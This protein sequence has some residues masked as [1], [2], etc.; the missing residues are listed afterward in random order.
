MIELIIFD[1]D[2]TLWR[3]NDPISGTPE[4]LNS[5][6]QKAVQIRFL[7]NNSSVSSL[8]VAEKLRSMGFIADPGEV[9]CSGPYA[10]DVCRSR[11][12]D[13]VYVIGGL[14]LERS[15]GDFRAPDAN[16]D[17]V[18]VGID[19][20]FTYDK[21]NQALQYILRG[22]AFIATNRDATY[23][24]EQ[25]RIV[26]GAGAIVASIEA[27]SGVEAEVLGKPNPGMILEILEKAGVI[28]GNC[29][30][31]GDRLDTDIKA[32][33]AAGCQTALV[34]TGA[35]MDPIPGVVTAVSVPDLLSRLP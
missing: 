21:C 24:M 29:L 30:V 33:W 28:P 8:D 18:V 14:G 32:G 4:A 15:F 10:A 20:E 6:R 22:A 7:T 11:G 2:G 34:L 23:P 5:L 3:G 13:Q 26:P 17:A 31:V 1:L 12:I 35:T 16:A 27:A 19:R 25:G 9:M